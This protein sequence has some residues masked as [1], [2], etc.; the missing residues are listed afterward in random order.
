VPLCDCSHGLCDVPT[1]ANSQYSCMLKNSDLCIT[2]H[3]SSCHTIN[4]PQCLLADRLMARTGLGSPSLEG[5]FQL[6]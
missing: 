3:L 4:R 5:V 1:T 2:V 6:D